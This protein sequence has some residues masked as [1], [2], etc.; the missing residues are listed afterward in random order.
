[1]QKLPLFL[2]NAR[3]QSTLSPLAFDF[4]SRELGREGQR[5]SERERE[6]RRRRRRTET[7]IVTDRQT[8]KKKPRKRGGAWGGGGGGEGLSGSVLNKRKRIAFELF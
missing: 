7:V 1:M 8:E 6:R 2:R 4:F 3:K 5:E